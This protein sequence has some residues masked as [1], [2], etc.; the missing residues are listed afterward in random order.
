MAC[1]QF[2][3]I[4]VRWTERQPNWLVGCKS[5]IFD[6]TG[7]RKENLTSYRMYARFQAFMCLISGH[8]SCKPRGELKGNPIVL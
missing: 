8:V 6:S 2:L 3:S 4:S 7:C 1:K 5:V